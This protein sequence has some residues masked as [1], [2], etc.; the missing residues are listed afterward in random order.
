[1]SCSDVLSSCT[2]IDMAHYVPADLRHNSVRPG[3]EDD[4]P[5]PLAYTPTPVVWSGSALEDATAANIIDNLEPFQPIDRLFRWENPDD[6]TDMLAIMA[7]IPWLSYPAHP[8]GNCRRANTSC[9]LLSVPIGNGTA[10]NECRQRHIT[11]DYPSNPLYVEAREENARAFRILVEHYGFERRHTLH[12]LSPR[13]FL[14]RLCLESYPQNFLLDRAA[15]TRIHYFAWEERQASANLA[16]EVWLRHVTRFETARRQGNQPPINEPALILP[17]PAVMAQVPFGV[18]V[19]PGAHMMGHPPAYA[20][21][22]QVFPQFQPLGQPQPVAHQPQ[23]TAPQPQPQTTEPQPQSQTTQQD[24]PGSLARL[25]TPSGR[26]GIA[27][28]SPTTPTPAVTQRVPG[29]TPRRISSHVGSGMVAPEGHVSRPATRGGGRGRGR[30]RGRG[31][32]ASSQADLRGASRQQ[33]EDD[34]A[35]ARELQRANNRTSTRVTRSMGD[36]S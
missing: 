28:N 15:T 32:R 19:A 35:L 29:S 14:D 11:C 6:L 30:G 4:P 34:R 16:R 24:A 10:C 23:P 27:P 5:L 8:C 17:E 7:G 18:P 22:Q 21:H 33:V 26:V 12:G 13:E 9:R 36:Q 31:S 1:M 20:A 25:G 3:Y 2:P